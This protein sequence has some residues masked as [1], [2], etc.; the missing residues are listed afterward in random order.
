[1]KQTIHCIN[2]HMNIL[3]K[4]LDINYMGLKAMKT[5]MVFGVLVDSVGQCF[6]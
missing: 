3:K 5:L 1:M 4:K 2:V 6:I